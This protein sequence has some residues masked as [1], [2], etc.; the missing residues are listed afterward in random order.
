MPGASSKMP[1]LFVG[2]GNP[3]NAIAQNSYSGG[4]RQIGESVPRPR[5]VLAISAHWYIPSTAVTAVDRPRTIHDFGGF[6]KALYEIQYPVPGDRELALRAQELLK[7]L[8]V[9]LDHDWGLDHGAWCVLMHVFP[10][11]DIPVVQLSIDMTKPASF[12]FETAKRLAPL[13]DE[14]VMIIG[15]GNIVHNLHAYAWGQRT[16]EPFDWAARFDQLVRKLLISGDYGRL[17]DY[18]ALGSDAAL[19]IPTPDHYLPLLYAIALRGEDEE[20]TFPVEG[21][22][23]GSV[24][25]LAV[26]IG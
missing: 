1:V 26:R 20:L 22:E 11:A 25:M 10:Q 18:K 16:V 5:A 8:N 17:V 7:P 24:S 14:Q 12:H 13:R 3:M 15:S 23:G 2:H 9:R 21:I 4:W 6:P 19:S